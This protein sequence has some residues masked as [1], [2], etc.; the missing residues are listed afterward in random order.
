[1]EVKRNKIL[2][3][4]FGGVGGAERMTL[5]IAKLLPKEQYEVKF[6]VCGRLKKI[7]DFI[8]DDYETEKIRWH[9]IHVFPRI[10]LAN[11]IRREKPDFVFSSTMQLNVLLLQVAKWMNVKCIVRNDN[12][13]CYVNEKLRRKLKKYYPLAYRIIAQQEEMQDDIIQLIG[14]DEE[15]VQCLHNPLDE[16]TIT[17]KLQAPSPY[18]ENDEVRYLWIANYLPAKGHDT[19]AK[20][21]KIVHDRNPKAHLYLV[22]QITD[23][24]PSYQWVKRF[25]ED[26][27]LQDYVHFMGYQPN[28]YVWIKHCDCFVL[29]SRMEG[30]PNVLLEAMFIRKPV[31]ATRCIPII[32]RM[33]DNGNNGYTVEVDNSEA[34]ASAMEKALL[35]K[36][37]ESNYKS[38][39]A[40]DFCKLFTS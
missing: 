27:N 4:L 6:V 22:G 40:E 36:D 18:N 1:M 11:V 15:K 5:T 8:P 9:N 21:F 25:V 24:F 2:F 35:L 14:S 20:A 34:M 29:P 30:L 26:N 32:D 17:Q 12:M 39:T 28:P 37:F 19:L 33:I 23:T 16:K 38:A 13:L 3:F 31:V 10:R 7:Y